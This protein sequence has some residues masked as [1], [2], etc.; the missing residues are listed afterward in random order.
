M[1]F[2][3]C[4]IA[5]CPRESVLKSC[6]YYDFLFAFFFFFTLLRHFKRFLVLLIFG[7]GVRFILCLYF[8]TLKVTDYCKGGLEK[9]YRNI[10]YN[11]DKNNNKNRIDTD[12][13]NEFNLKIY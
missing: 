4:Y 12:T 13:I 7:V 1:K 9:K 3:V 5:S 10:K 2:C 8:E 6:N 11:N